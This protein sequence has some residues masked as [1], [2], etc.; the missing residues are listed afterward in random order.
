MATSVKKK[1]KSR[2][3][4]HPNARRMVN[5]MKQQGYALRFP[6]DVPF[7][8][9][10]RHIRRKKP[11]IYIINEGTFAGTQFWPVNIWR[12]HEQRRKAVHGVAGVEATRT[13]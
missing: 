10:M 1:H 12:Q 5:A 13:E 3:L 11:D 6:S 2:V 7:A 4:V 9:M 8:L